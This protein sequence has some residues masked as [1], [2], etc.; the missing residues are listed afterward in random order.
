MKIRLLRW[1]YSSLQVGCSG[2]KRKNYRLLLLVLFSLF[3]SVL[4]AQQRVTLAEAYLRM[5]KPAQTEQQ[6]QT[7]INSGKF[8]L[9]TARFGVRAN[10]PG[11]PFSDMFIYGNQ[12]RSQGNNEVIWTF[13]M[14]HPANVIGGITNNPQH[15]RVW[16]AAYYQVQGMKL[17]DTTGGRGLARLR[18]NNFVNYGLY[19]S[20]DMRNSHYNFRRQYWYNDPSKPDLL[21]KP[22]PYSGFD[23]LYRINPHTTK[24]YQFDP[25]DEFGF[26]MIKDIILM[27]LG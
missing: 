9:T 18:L 2:N 14:E 26:A 4:F 7:I 21:G 23:T 6:A 11:D 5:D 12:R 1:K 22:V 10:Q 3:S 16:V 17:T 8:S 24:W 25:K 19:E 20:N 13:E 27:R 15:R